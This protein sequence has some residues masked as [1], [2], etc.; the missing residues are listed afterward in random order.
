MH[1]ER[2]AELHAERLAKRPT[3]EG[4]C[5]GI[6]SL[7]E[8]IAALFAKQQK[9]PGA[10]GHF[11]DGIAETA[12]ADGREECSHE[13][14]HLVLGAGKGPSEGQLAALACGICHR[15]K[16]PRAQTVCLLLHRAV[17]GRLLAEVATGLAMPEASNFI[18]GGSC[19]EVFALGR[20][21]FRQGGLLPP[22]AAVERFVVATESLSIELPS[23]CACEL[24]LWHFEPELPVVC[25]WRGEEGPH[26]RGVRAKS[27]TL[28]ALYPYPDLYRRL[29][30]SEDVERVAADIAGRCSEPSEATAAELS[31]FAAVRTLARQAAVEAPAQVALAGRAIGLLYRSGAVR[32]AVA[33]P[34][35]CGG[36]READAPAA[37]TASAALAGPR[38]VPAGDL[39]LRLAPWASGVDELQLL[40]ICDGWGIL[41]A[42]S[43]IAR[44]CLLAFGLADLRLWV[45]GASGEVCEL[46]CGDLVGPAARQDKAETAA[47][48]EPKRQNV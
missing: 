12:A 20:L 6:R 7:L 9:H 10:L 39:V 25:A 22:A 45:H 8:R 34:S 33:A 41:H 29:T 1:A 48:A 2:P 38:A 37:A 44:E 43:G 40:L 31:L 15:L 36:D 47:S 23:P 5:A 21:L 32:T 17:D 27:L 11:G 26:G 4:C 30:S 13:P 42:P 28:G 3:E 14:D 46:S 24:L 19:A 35:P 18:P 16:N